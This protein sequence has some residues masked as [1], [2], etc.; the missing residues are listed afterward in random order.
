MQ[1]QD[2]LPRTTAVPQNTSPSSRAILKMME[3]FVTLE[4]PCIA[5][6][7]HP[8]QSSSCSMDILPTLVYFSLLI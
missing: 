1:L 5:L 2:F 6:S 8:V 3:T 7:F 4:F